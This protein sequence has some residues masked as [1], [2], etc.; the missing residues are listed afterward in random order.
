MTITCFVKLRLLTPKNQSFFACQKATQTIRVSVH[1]MCYVKRTKI[2][3]FMHNSNL[4]FLS[5]V[6][7]TI[8]ISCLAN[9]S[10]AQ[11]LPPTENAS[12]L[13][14]AEALKEDPS[15]IHLSGRNTRGSSKLFVSLWMTQIGKYRY[16]FQ[17]FIYK[18]KIA[19]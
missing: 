9:F 7:S 16:V 3:P 4:K 5:N 10:P 8:V 13:L 14:R 2:L 15:T 18:C 11:D 17:F 19:R 1:W 6:E 12:N